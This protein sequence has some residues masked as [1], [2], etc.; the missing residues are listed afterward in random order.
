MPAPVSEIAGTP[1]GEG[2][3]D[4]RRAL[5]LTGRGDTPSSRDR[6]RRY[7]ASEGSS[8]A[9]PIAETTRRGATRRLMM[10]RDAV[11]ASASASDEPP[12][13]DDERRRHRRI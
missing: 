5:V 1:I 3:R 11:D 8:V 12:T 2:H 4:E 6:A 13:S 9:S 10:P 7:A